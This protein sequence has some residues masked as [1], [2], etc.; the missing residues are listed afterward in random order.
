MT[1]QFRRGLCLALS[2][3]VRSAAYPQHIKNE[4]S[5]NFLINNNNAIFRRSSSVRTLSYPLLILTNEKAM[6]VN[7]IRIIEGRRLEMATTSMLALYS[8]SKY[9]FVNDI[10]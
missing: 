3:R 5:P 8:N 1:N 4:Y 6:I 9:R 2:M 7:I 10:F